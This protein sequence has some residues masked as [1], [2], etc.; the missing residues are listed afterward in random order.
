MKLSEAIRAGADIVEDARGV[1][2]MIPG[3][4]DYDGDKPCGCAIGTALYVCGERKVGS[5]YR[6]EMLAKAFPVAKSLP[7]CPVCNGQKALF[8]DDPKK[9]PGG[10]IECLYEHHKWS[11]KAISEW[12]EVQEN[13]IEAEMAAKPAKAPSPRI[14]CPVS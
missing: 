13:R 4:K 12:V 6:F 7:L 5:C 14:D 10:A 1:T 2:L 3:D 9:S 8:G 11:R